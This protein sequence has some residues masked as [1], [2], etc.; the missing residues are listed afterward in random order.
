MRLLLCF[1]IANML[2]TID[3][4]RKVMLEEK[5]KVLWE[6]Q[7][8]QPDFFFFFGLLWPNLRHM[9]VPRVGVELEL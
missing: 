9:E 2:K 1:M 7:D 5:G 4:N 6:T 8:F 3:L